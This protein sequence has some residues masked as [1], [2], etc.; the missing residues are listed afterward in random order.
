MS[1]EGEARSGRPSTSRNEEVIEKVCQIVVKDR[2][3]TLRK[4]VE[5]VG[6]SRGSVHS[7]LIEDL[8]RHHDAVRRK[9]PDMWTGKNW[10]H[11]HDTASRSFRPCNQR[12]FGQK[13]YGTGATASLLS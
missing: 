1:I 8:R 9:R 12:F 10:Q 11:H 7:I 4:I 6:I 5:K 2:P 3:L 13:Q